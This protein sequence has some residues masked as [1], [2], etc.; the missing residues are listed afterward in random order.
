MLENN[1]KIT[2]TTN[3]SVARMGDDGKVLMSVENGE[4]YGFGDIETAIWD[5]FYA[6]ST[7]TELV[8]NLCRN[9]DVTPAQCAQDIQPFL[10]TMFEKK[11][12]EY[13]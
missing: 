2:R 9:F 1:R 5:A 11:L 12:F 8:E 3:I 10:E 6:P 13:A 7:I 4:Y